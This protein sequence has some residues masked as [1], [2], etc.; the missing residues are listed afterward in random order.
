MKYWAI[1][2]NGEISKTSTK[3]VRP[4]RAIAEM[5]EEIYNKLFKLIDFQPTDPITG[6][7]QVV[8][9]YIPILDGEG[10]P[11]F[12]GVEIPLL[13]ELDR[14]LLDQD[15]NALTET[16]QEQQF[17]QEESAYI[18]KKA[19]I[20]QDAQDALDIAD[21]IDAAAAAEVL[22]FEK[23]YAFARK[24]KIKIAIINS[25]KDW[26]IA[27][28]QAYLTNASIQQINALISD[29]SFASAKAVVDATDLSAFYSIEE[30]GEISTMIGD[31]LTAEGV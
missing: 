27:D 18:I 3:S 15:G 17:S 28:T 12:V 6:L 2:I 19:V 23:R 14:P 8:I 26:D 22:K 9:E 24:I 10:N 13:D 1:E 25:K 7:P 29:I 11:V 31:Y 21:E 4:K 30:V 16:I 5:E 20:D